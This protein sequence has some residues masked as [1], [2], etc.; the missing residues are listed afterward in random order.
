MWNFL[1]CP[2]CRAGGMGI[3][4]RA[5]HVL[6]KS[7]LVAIK[8]MKEESSKDNIQRKRFLNEALIIDQLHHPNIVKVIERG[9]YNNRLFIAMELLEGKPLSYLI[10]SGLKL[11]LK[12]AAAIMFQLLDAI[13]KIHS[14]GIIHRDL[15]PDN[16]ML[17]DKEKES[18]NF[19]KILDF[20]LA[21]NRSLTQL[22]ATGE[23]LGTI[24]YLPPERISN[25]DISEAG[26]IYSLGVIFYEMMTLDKP[27]L[28]ELQVDVI[29]SILEKEPIE[30]CR[31]NSDIPDQLNELIM[32]MMYKDPNA[33]PTEIELRQTVAQY[34]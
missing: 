7:K 11:P 14:K 23:I 31:F 8:V 13:S 32:K 19:V 33:R 24:N 26:D 34:L 27:F 6:D 2:E 25:Q 17:I 5:N 15:K 1:V 20:V 28:G 9:E 3:V 4:Y 30:P 10:K 18:Q 29:R 12:E 22:T 21:K 16:I